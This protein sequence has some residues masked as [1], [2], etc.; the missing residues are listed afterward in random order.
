M[1]HRSFSIQF[2]LMIAMRY[3][4]IGSFAKSITCQFWKI[5]FGIS[6]LTWFISCRIRTI[7]ENPGF[8]EFFVKIIFGQNSYPSFIYMIYKRI[9]VQNANRSIYT[10]LGTYTPQCYLIGYLYPNRFDK[11]LF[12]SSSFLEIWTSRIIII[13]LNN[14]PGQ[15]FKGNSTKNFMTQSINMKSI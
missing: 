3:F 9:S 6:L 12:I 2:Q 1:Y 8:L 7:I 13:Q 14:F 11:T 4:T 10:S 15:F 5:V